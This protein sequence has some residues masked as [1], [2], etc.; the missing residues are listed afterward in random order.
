MKIVCLKYGEALYPHKRLVADITDDSEIPLSF[1]FYLI[2]TENK[3]ILV[4]TGCDGVERYK[5]YVH[6][7]PIDLLGEYG[8]S[9]EDITD[10]IITH[11]HFD[12]IDC[13]GAYKGA[14]IHI[15]KDEFERAKD[16]LDS[17]YKCNVFEDSTEIC[18]DIRVQKIGGHTK[19]SCAVFAGK[20][21]LCGD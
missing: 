9:P 19:G 13:I 7:H 6:K 3:K 2:I 4:D 12:H 11:T 15:Q 8:L 14:Q 21:I 17:E 10:V 20:Y 5:M 1:C 18:K 16:Y